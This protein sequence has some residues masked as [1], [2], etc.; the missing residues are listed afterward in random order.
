MNI[1]Q[2]IFEGKIGD[3]NTLLEKNKTYNAAMYSLAIYEET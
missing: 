1:K 3:V 2:A